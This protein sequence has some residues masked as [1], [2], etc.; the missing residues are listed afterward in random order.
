MPGVDWYYTA[1]HF[2]QTG[3]GAA[4]P[5]TRMSDQ[6]SVS[7]RQVAWPPT[8]VT[9]WAPTDIEIMFRGARVGYTNLGVQRLTEKV[10][11]LEADPVKYPVRL[12]PTVGLVPIEVVVMRSPN[13]PMTEVTRDQQLAFWDQVATTPFTSRIVDSHGRLTSLSVQFP[14]WVYSDTEGRG[15]YINEGLDA[16]TPD[17][18]WSW[19]GERNGRACGVQ[20]RLVNFFYKD[21]DN[22]HVFPQKQANPGNDTETDDL[23]G[24]GAHD[25]SPCRQNLDEARSDPRHRPGTVVMIFMEKVSF[26]STA[27]IG[28]GMINENAACVQRN[29]QGNPN[30]IAHELGHAAGLLDVCPNG[31][32]KMMCSGGAGQPYPNEQQCTHLESWA[33]SLSTFFARP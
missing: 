29:T 21:T 13:H 15:L 22:K 26:S 33:Q 19:V 17:S 32:E 30:L 7:D 4:S 1:F 6:G 12:R 2:D 25:D 31:N 24:G 28:Q 27:H 20:F 8:D 3:A 18:A 14:D 5:V 10:T 9:W 16:Y 11:T 23:F